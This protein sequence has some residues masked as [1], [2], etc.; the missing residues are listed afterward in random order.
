FTGKRI[1]VEIDDNSLLMLDFGDAM[2]AFLDATYCV[3]A[4]LGPRLEIYGS[5]GTLSLG[6]RGAGTALQ[7]YRSQTKEWASVDAPRAPNVRDLGVLH[8]VERLLDGK[9]LAL[10]AEHGRHLVEIMTAAPQAAQDGRTVEM[11]TTF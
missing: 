8:M 5:E 3:E 11:Q 4:S 10:T 1:D 7:L 2:F 6:G 9:D